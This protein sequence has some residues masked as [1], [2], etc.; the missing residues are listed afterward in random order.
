MTAGSAEKCE[1]CRALGADLAV[2]YREEDFVVAVREMTA[3][4]GVDVVLD[5]SRF[6]LA[7]RVRQLDRRPSKA[8]PAGA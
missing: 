8:P 4:R 1:R 6:L 2:N 7:H 5:A 3:G